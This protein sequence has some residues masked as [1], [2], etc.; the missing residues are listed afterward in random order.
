[1]DI[2]I[3]IPFYFIHKNELVY[4]L[5]YKLFN[6][7]RLNLTFKSDKVVLYQLDM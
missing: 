5:I 4:G 6:N 2:I 3:L 7:I 1:M